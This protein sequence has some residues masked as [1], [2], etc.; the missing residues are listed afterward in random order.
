MSSN[1]Q[2]ESSFIVT[3]QDG[4]R[5]DTPGPI[6]WT[7]IGKDRD[8][9]NPYKWELYIPHLSRGDRG[10]TYELGGLSTG[11]EVY[12]SGAVSWPGK[13]IRPFP[14]Y[15]EAMAFVEATF[16]LEHPEEVS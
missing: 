4:N 16:A 10:E 8:D 2:N 12:R 11:I 14:T 3:D 7:P 1:K 9:S 6:K 15:Q 13:D 5:V